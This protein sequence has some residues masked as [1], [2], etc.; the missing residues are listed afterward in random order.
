M[1]Q[2]HV[3]LLKK[4]SHDTPDEIEYEPY[5]GESRDE[6]VESERPV[7]PPGDEH[8]DEESDRDGDDETVKD[9]K[10]RRRLLHGTIRERQ[11][12]RPAP[13]LPLKL[14]PGRTV[15]VFDT[16]FYIGRLDEVEAVVGSGAWI[17]SLPLVV[18]T[19]LDG[20]KTNPG[21]ISLCANRALAFIDTTLASPTTRPHLKL[22]T[23]SGNFLPNL[24][25]R[26]ERFGDGKKTNDDVV[27]ACARWWVGRAGGAPDGA[28]DVVLVTEDVNLRLKARASG[29]H[30][31]EA[32]H[33]FGVGKAG[34]GRT[35]ERGR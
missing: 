7:K 20:L 27:L 30:V 22:Q 35:A 18:V 21:P 17:V 19:E 26:T 8:V 33:G 29:V 24:S 28:A 23:A 5:V 25:V 34:R 4:S 16:N 15:V 32:V 31:V 12:P 9:L 2:H 13:S 6:E 1:T 10:S 3:L 14:V 11:A